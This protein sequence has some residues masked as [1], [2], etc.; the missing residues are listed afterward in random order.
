MEAIACKKTN[1]YNSI[2][3]SRIIKYNNLLNIVFSMQYAF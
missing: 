2:L 3:L 1:R